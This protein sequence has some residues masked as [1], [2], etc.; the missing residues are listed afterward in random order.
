M[1]TNSDSQKIEIT[2][3]DFFFLR[4]YI[5]EDCGLF[6]NADK[7]NILL[8]FVPER[9]LELKLITVEE[10][11]NCITQNN[12]ALNEKK[13]LKDILIKDEA[14]FFSNH[15]QLDAIAEIIIPDILIKEACSDQKII[16]I[17]N[18]SK[19]GGE[20]AYTIAIVLRNS[21]HKQ[22]KEK[23]FEITACAVG[24]TVSDSLVEESYDEKSL[25]GMNMG[26]VKKYF[27]KTADERFKIKDEYRI[28]I[29]FKTINLMNPDNF[30]IFDNFDLIICRNIL[31]FFEKN[32]RQQLVEKFHF[33]LKHDGLLLLGEAES[34]Y[35]IEKH[36]KTIVFPG[37]LAYEKKQL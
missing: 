12:Q 35:G 28:A 10:Y 23:V 17:L 7:K 29:D 32:Y 37:T 4:N 36:F 11:L 31:I 33:L 1:D 18:I 15:Y 24:D 8:S 16:R 26:Q 30:N 27:L 22:Y 6:I 5:Y 14:V 13:Y 25:A 19:L 34:L 21:F 3:S 2:D 20:E 9:M